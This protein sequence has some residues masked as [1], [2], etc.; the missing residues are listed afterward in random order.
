MRVSE[1]KEYKYKTSVHQC[2]TLTKVLNTSHIHINIKGKKCV[3]T[4]LKL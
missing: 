1:T 3:Q 2:E 4:L